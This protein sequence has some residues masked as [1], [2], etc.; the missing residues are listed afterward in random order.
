[1][2]VG[3]ALEDLFRDNPR[4]RE[5]LMI[6]TKV[7][8]YE[9][10]PNKQF[11]FSKTATLASVQKSLDQLKCGYIDVL[12]LHDPEFA[13]SLEQLM[14][15]TIPAMMECRE[16]GQC[17]ALGLTGYSLEVQYQIFQQSLELYGASVWDQSLTYGHFN[18]HDKSLTTTRIANHSSFAEFCE[19]SKLLLLAAAPFSMGLLAGNPP[20]AWHPACEQLKQA[21]RDAT[22]ICKAHGIKIS[23]L[24]LCVALADPNIPCTI[25]GMKDVG[26]VGAVWSVTQR[27]RNVDDSLTPDEILKQILTKEEHKAWEILRDP[28]NGPFATVWSNG[29]F[30]WDG[31][32]AA[33]EFWKQVDDTSMVEEWQRCDY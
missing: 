33:R 27:M 1:V 25:V 9:A 14:N 21:C 8:R 32:Q 17:R 31:V 11:D 16:T 23:T 19:K 20:P 29:S 10:D 13:P 6:N 18:L 28:V 4:A 22:E 24:A 30:K 2:V 12:Q 7:G 5:K 15:E 3:W 26:E